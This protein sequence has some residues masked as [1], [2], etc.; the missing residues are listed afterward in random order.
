MG[1]DDMVASKECHGTY[2]FSLQDNGVIAAASAKGRSP[3]FRLNSV[4]RAL[5][6]CQL[7][8]D[9]V[10]I[11]PWVQSSDQP[12][13]EASRDEDD[14]VKAFRDYLVWSES[15]AITNTTTR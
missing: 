6:A 15:R 10:L 11:A 8:A 5:N 4:L 12:A 3:V 2:V 7:A 9:V 1:V 14:R 13:D